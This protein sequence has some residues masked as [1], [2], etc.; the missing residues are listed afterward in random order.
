MTYW[1]TNS[2]ITPDGTILTC[3]D[4]H[5]YQSHFDEVS[6]ETYMT[7]GL[8]WCVRRS[9]NDTPYVDLSVTSDSPFVEVRG[10]PLWKSYGQNGEYP[11]GRY[12]AIKDMTDEHISNILLTQRRIKGTPVEELFIKE[13]LH[14]INTKKET[15]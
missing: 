12:M 8:G 7:D 1:F 4:S 6:K 15:E 3:Y 11:N 9:V 5:D 14:R 10:V 2:I 13:Q